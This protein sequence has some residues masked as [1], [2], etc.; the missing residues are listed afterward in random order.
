MVKTYKDVHFRITC[1]SSSHEEVQLNYTN[2]LDATCC[3]EDPSPKVERKTTW[4]IDEF[5]KHCAED[6][7]NAS[8]EVCM[9]CRAQMETMT[10]AIVP[11]LGKA[12]P[13]VCENFLSFVCCIM[14]GFICSEIRVLIVESR[15]IS[16]NSLPATR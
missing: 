15:C 14:P 12:T 11:M 5:V 10:E 1:L 16:S 9:H 4:L 2:Q 13:M 3:V 8:A 7:L 6:I